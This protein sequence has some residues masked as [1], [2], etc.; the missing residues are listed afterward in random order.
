MNNTAGFTE[1]SIVGK[2]SGEGSI[3]SWWRWRRLC[4]NDSIGGGGGERSGYSFLQLEI[5]S[6][7]K[8]GFKGEAER[9][10]RVTTK[11]DVRERRVSNDRRKKKRVKKM[12]MGG[13]IFVKECRIDGWPLDG[14]H[15]QLMDDRIQP[16]CQGSSITLHRD[17]PR[18]LGLTTSSRLFAE[19]VRADHKATTWGFDL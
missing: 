14:G 3:P 5:V 19:K 1:L 13:G 9:D 16:G 10:V 7:I 15:G 12:K 6:K 4:G 8:V 17:W 18:R 11:R 2:E